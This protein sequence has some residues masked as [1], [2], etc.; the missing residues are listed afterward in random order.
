MASP[1]LPTALG[2]LEATAPAVSLVPERRQPR[3]EMCLLRSDHVPR[4]A[5]CTK[6]SM[7]GH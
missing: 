3:P 7:L 5:S 1:E 2:A 4:G 6:A